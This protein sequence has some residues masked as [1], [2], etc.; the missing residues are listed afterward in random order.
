[1]KKK[2]H[3]NFLSDLLNRRST[4]RSPDVMVYGWIGGKHACVD[5]TGV[6]HSWDYGSKF[7]R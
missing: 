4:L 2:A 5:L 6:H 7:L 1:M 3:L